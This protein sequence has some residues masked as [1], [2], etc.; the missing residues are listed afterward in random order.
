MAANRPVVIDWIDV[1]SGHPLADFARTAILIQYGAPPP[2]N[3]LGLI[4]QLGRGKLYQVYHQR[5][6]ELSHANPTDVQAW[7]PVIAAARLSEGIAEEE[8]T[9]VSIVQNA[10]SPFPGAGS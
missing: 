1:T 10:F 8:S 7:I 3:P 9:L 5:Y 2:Q 6:F 4:I